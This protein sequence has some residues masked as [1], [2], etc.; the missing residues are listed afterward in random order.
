MNCQDF[1]NLIK[2]RDFLHFNIIWLM[3]PQNPM[4]ETNAIQ[5][6]FLLWFFWDIP[7]WS[8]WICPFFCTRLYGKDI[9]CGRGIL[10]SGYL[11]IYSEF[12]S[13]W[14]TVHLNQNDYKSSYNL[15]I[16][17]Y[18]GPKALSFSSLKTRNEAW[19]TTSQMFRFKTQSH[20]K[21][22]RSS[23]QRLNWVERLHCC[24]LMARC[25]KLFFPLEFKGNIL[26]LLGDRS[27]HTHSTQKRGSL[28]PKIK[29]I[30][31]QFLEI[32]NLFI[33]LE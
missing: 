32:M 13:F 2:L 12:V 30:L 28:W 31:I 11:L 7:Q 4:Y 25:W 9:H 29:R 16:C 8:G 33:S 27:M 23:T 21:L 6:Q 5:L 18:F 15:I 20:E 3:F 19:Y 14:G 1:N 22:M 24:Y 10:F 26:W 17:I